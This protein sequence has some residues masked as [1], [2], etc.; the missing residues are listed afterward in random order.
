MQLCTDGVACS[1][2]KE[3][4]KKASVRINTKRVNYKKNDKEIINVLSDEEQKDDISDVQVLLLN[5]L[6]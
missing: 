5:I 6:S 1:V 2:S 4:E 3:D